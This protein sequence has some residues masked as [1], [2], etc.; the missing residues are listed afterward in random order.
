MLKAP[1]INLFL[2]LISNKT[3][4]C[5]I[6]NKI[7]PIYY[8]NILKNFKKKKINHNIHQV[9]HIKIVQSNIVIREDQN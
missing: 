7:Y 1:M 4:D 6:L 8:I 2:I 3:M 9:I 5:I